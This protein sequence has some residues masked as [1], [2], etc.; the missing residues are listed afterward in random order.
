MRIEYTVRKFTPPS[1]VSEWDYN[2]LKAALT[3]DPSLQIQPSLEP[4]TFEFR[5]HFRILFYC[6][7]ILAFSG[8]LA[9]ISESMSES[10]LLL[11]IAGFF[12][13]PSMFMLMVLPVAMLGLP[14][15]AKARRDE[16][17]FYEKLF[18]S[19]KKSKGYDEFI[20][21]WKK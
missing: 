5:N 13:L 7:L 2:E 14:S 18:L 4:V 8:C 11:F 6:T 21:I 17:R 10:Q 9:W 12:A 15:Y 1:H 20:R 16:R 3:R 19:V